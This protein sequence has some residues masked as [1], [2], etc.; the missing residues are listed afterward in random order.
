[1]RDAQGGEVFVEKA[2][3]VLGFR[4]EVVSGA[5]EAALTFIG[6]LSGLPVAETPGSRV[7]V[8]DIGGGSTELIV[9][10]LGQTPSDPPQIEQSTSLNI[11]S[12]RLTERNQLSDPPDHNQLTQVREQVQSALSA[13]GIAPS[14]TLT[15]VGVAGTV[16][17]LA[18]ISENMQTYDAARIHGHILDKAEIERVSAELSSLSLEKRLQIPGLS[19]GRADVIVCGSI[20]CDEIARFA[21]AREIVVSDRGVRFGLLAEMM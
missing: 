10:T 11:G 9:G 7:F 8:F 18:A 19:K 17:T 16:T 12:V 4:P 2:T 20:L 3:A 21:G 15:V 14:G 1:M 5:R 6:A 13:S